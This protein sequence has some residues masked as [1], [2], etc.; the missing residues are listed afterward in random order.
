MSKEYELVMDEQ[1]AI[2]F[3]PSNKAEE[4]IQ[5]VITIC[6]TPKGSRPMDREFGINFLMVDKPMVK[7]QARIT[8]EI[9]EAVKKYEPRAEIVSV[10][11]GWSES[12]G[13]LWPEVK[14]RVKE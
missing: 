2:N 9:V 5:N 3:K 4:I 7:E 13:V 1:T 11:M 10:G 12:R 6:T 8:N 14:I